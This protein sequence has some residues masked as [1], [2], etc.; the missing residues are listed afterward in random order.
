MTQ[1]VTQSGRPLR[2][3]SL[4][5]TEV[6][7]GPAQQEDSIVGAEGP[8]KAEGSHADHGEAWFLVFILS[9]VAPGRN[10]PIMKFA[11]T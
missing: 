4:G 11:I 2:G 1:L 10:V 3:C 5:P 8:R 9:K 6:H 7:S